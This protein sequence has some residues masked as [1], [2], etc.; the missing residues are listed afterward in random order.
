VRSSAALASEPAVI[1]TPSPGSWHS[2]GTAGSR[3][4]TK[5]R[6][7][8]STSGYEIC[9]FTGMR[10]TIGSVL[11]GCGVALLL[12]A[13]GGNAEGNPGSESGGAGH[14]GA[15][16]A[17][18]GAGAMPG[19]GGTSAQGG[20]PGNGGATN[21]GAMSCCLALAI[22]DSGDTQLKDGEA[23]PSGGDC[24]S[25]SICCSTVR[26]MRP[27]AQ[28]NAIP[29][30]DEGDKQ[31]QG[32]CP[33]DLRCYTRT[34][35]GT[36]INCLGSAC[37]RGAEYNRKYAT[38]SHDSCALIDF[39]CPANTEYFINDCGCGCQQD[40]SCP[41]FVNCQPRIDD[42]PLSVLCSDKATCPYTQRPI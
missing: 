40:E 7:F 13:C 1:T 6:V 9:C 30:C 28:C 18:G 16:A 39:A 27:A 17:S 36:T 10:V 5:A 37:D 24:Y 32:E 35:C 4:S 26:C 20:A 19:K 23:C 38:T 21:G 34:L 2:A 33:P 41:Q 12:G 29:L 25:R 14:G 3:L 31:I 15:T 11:L 42:V 22:C 8:S